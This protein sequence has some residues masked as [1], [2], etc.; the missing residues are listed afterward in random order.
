MNYY[1][2]KSADMQ[3]SIISTANSLEGSYA[4]A[5][6]NSHTPHT[7]YTSCKGSPIILG[8]GVD[9]NYISSDITPIIDHTKHFIPMDDSE[10]AE[11]N[12]AGIKIFNKSKKINDGNKILFNIIFFIQF[13]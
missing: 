10:F 1:F 9:A 6:I 2:N 3:S 4:I 5:A 8:K 7:I 12:S 13:K 11:I